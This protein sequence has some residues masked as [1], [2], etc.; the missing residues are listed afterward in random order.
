MKLISVSIKNN[1]SGLN[2]VFKGI[3]YHV[4]TKEDV[5]AVKACVRN[6]P[7][8]QWAEKLRD[9]FNADNTIRIRV[10]KGIFRKGG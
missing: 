4:K 10:E 8:N 5:E 2:H 9:K 7:F 6:V 3:A 1:I